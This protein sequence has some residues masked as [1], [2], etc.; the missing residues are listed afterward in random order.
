LRP[1]VGQITSEANSDYIVYEKG[2]KLYDSRGKVAARPDV[3]GKVDKVTGKWLST[4]DYTAAEKQK[5]A[6]LGI[7][8]GAI[9]L[10]ENIVYA[11]FRNAT[12]SCGISMPFITTQPLTMPASNSGAVAFDFVAGVLNYGA[13]S[14]ALDAAKCLTGHMVQIMPS[15]I[16]VGVMSNGLYRPSDGYFYLQG[17]NM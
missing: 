5:L 13:T 17:F 1:T 15:I 4:E 8:G 2:G 16:A 14:N 12:R 3:D 7:G 10:Y 11:Y 9:T 6:G